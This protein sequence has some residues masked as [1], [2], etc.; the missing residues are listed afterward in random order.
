[1]FLILLKMDEVG[2]KELA[3]NLEILTTKAKPRHCIT[4]R[5]VMPTIGSEAFSVAFIV[6][7]SESDCGITKKEKVIPA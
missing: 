5:I 1:M 4:L 3:E 6:A 2:G 7:F